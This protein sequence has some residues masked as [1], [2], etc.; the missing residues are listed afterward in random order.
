[1]RLSLITTTL[2][3]LLLFTTGAQGFQSMKFTGN[4]GKYDIELE[5]NDFDE[6]SG[7]FMGRY[8]YAGKKK[9]LTIN[10]ESNDVV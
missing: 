1:M 2:F 3:I 7:E 6:P 10:G 8:R 5:I 9:W 4:I